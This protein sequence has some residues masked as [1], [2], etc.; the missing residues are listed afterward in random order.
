MHT[1]H[2]VAN[3][4]L[5]VTILYNIMWPDMKKWG[6][7]AQNTP[8]KIILLISSSKFCVSYVS[9][10]NYLKFSTAYCSSYKGFSNTLYFGMKL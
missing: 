3:Y 8:L 7:Y 4:Y 10:V 9:S 6:L 1:T 5:C 2:Y